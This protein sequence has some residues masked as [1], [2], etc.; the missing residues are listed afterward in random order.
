MYLY[1]NYQDANLTAFHAILC[2]I[3]YGLY[4]LVNSTNFGK[5]MYLT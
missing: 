2:V 3:I 4:Y 5:K 1:F